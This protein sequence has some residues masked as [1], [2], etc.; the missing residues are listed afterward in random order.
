MAARKTID[1]R[2]GPLPEIHAEGDSVTFSLDIPE[3]ANGS[4]LLL[5]CDAAGDVWVSIVSA[6][7]SFPRPFMG[8]E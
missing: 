8:G 5:R 7:Q 2:P 6:H 4:R 1:R 3:L